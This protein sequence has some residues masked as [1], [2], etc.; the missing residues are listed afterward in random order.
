MD[1]FVLFDTVDFTE[2]VLAAMDIDTEQEVSM[3]AIGFGF[4]FGRAGRK[5]RLEPNRENLNS[6]ATTS[7][8]PSFDSNSK[9]EALKPESSPSPTR[10]MRVYTS[11]R[12]R[13]QPACML[14]QLLLL[15]Y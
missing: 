5:D 9:L 3:G 7:A 13:S 1:L 12:T 2:L 4:G 15:Y 14:L 8:R 10:R 11:A 6:T